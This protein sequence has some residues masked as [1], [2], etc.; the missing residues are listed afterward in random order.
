[1]TSDVPDLH[2]YDF[3]NP[4]EDFRAKNRD[5]LQVDFSQ[6]VSSYYNLP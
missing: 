4:A 5:Q 3:F 1:M 2:N 6:N